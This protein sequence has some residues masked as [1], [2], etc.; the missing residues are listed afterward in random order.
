MIIHSFKRV[1]LFALS[2][3][4]PRRSVPRNDARQSSHNGLS[5]NKLKMR[6]L[7]GFIQRQKAIID[8]YI[9]CRRCGNYFVNKINE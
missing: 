7:Y 1:F 5:R 8:H 3:G 2:Y 9:I 6:S 4:L